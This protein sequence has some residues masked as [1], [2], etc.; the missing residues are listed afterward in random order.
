MDLWG[1]T[2]LFD[3]IVNGPD[4]SSTAFIEPLP[5][6]DFVNQLLNRDISSRPLSDADRVKVR[7]CSF[8]LFL[9][10]C[11]SEFLMN[12]VIKFSQYVNSFP[13]CL[14]LCQIYFY[15]V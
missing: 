14:F 12:Y 5:I 4:M 15:F 2:L 13:C 7:F 9:N 8:P 1:F 6:I 10:Y 3:K 11:V